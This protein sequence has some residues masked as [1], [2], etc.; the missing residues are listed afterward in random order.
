MLNLGVHMFQRSRQERR[1]QFG[2][3]SA[4]NSA[5]KSAKLPETNDRPMND[6]LIGPN[7][8]WKPGRGQ[9]GLLSRY[10]AVW[11]ALG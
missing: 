1:G 3:V 5:K 10:A 7:R 2:A 11:D 9:N 4:R 6:R 8:F